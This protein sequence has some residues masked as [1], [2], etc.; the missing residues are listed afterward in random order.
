METRSF[1]SLRMTPQRSCTRGNRAKLSP[2]QSD[3]VSYS[4]VMLSTFAALSVNSA[5]HLSAHRG[6]SL[7]SL[8][9][10]VFGNL[11]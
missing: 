11:S 2:C 4:P 6:R 8:R 7:A 5:K 3:V 10:T 9:V 1:A